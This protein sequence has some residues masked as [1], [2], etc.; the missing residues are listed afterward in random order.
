MKSFSKFIFFAFLLCLIAL[1]AFLFMFGIDNTPMVEHNKTL[2]FDNIKKAKQ[3]IKNNKPYRFS[4]KKTKELTINEDDLNL[5]ISYAISHGLDASRLSAKVQLLEN[6]LNGFSTI[7]LPSLSS[8]LYINCKLTF[9][10]TVNFLDLTTCH[11]GR[12]KIPKIITKFILSTSHDLLLKND[13]YKNFWHNIQTIKQILIKNKKATVYYTPNYNLIR[14]LQESGKSFLLTNEQQR[15]LVMYH[16]HL[17][18]LSKD[19]MREQN[20]LLNIMKDMF[21][22]AAENTQKSGD[23]I[24][25]NTTAIQVLSL[26]AI[27][28]RLDH[29]L[30]K[31]YKYK[32]KY[33]R[34]NRLLFNNRYD[35]P[36]HFL[37]SAAITVSAGSKFAHLVG[38]AKEIEDSG[39]GSGFSFADLAADKAGVKFGELAITSKSQAILFQKKISLVDNENQIM[40]SISNLPEGIMELEFKRRYKELDSKAYQL[41]NTEIDKRLDQCRLYQ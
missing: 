13:L 17:S 28:Q 15:K 39:G 5:L 24:L 11:I 4:R 3:L 21:D 38:L 20:S 2:S 26:Y 36:K 18:K 34:R 32:I 10:P 9:K 7:Q 30:N 14:A 37:V 31:E 27:G 29:L 6:T 16:N 41:I 35:L 23:P 22:F 40:P 33:A 12:I 1:P 19:H 8:D 25:E